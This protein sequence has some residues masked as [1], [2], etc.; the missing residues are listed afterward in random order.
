MP[1]N[2]SLSP[3]RVSLVRKNGNKKTFLSL[4]LQILLYVWLFVYLFVCLS[5]YAAAPINASDSVFIRTSIS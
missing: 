3:P 2:Y 4:K 5:F 1:R